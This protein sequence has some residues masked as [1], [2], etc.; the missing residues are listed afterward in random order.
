LPLP[1]L[2]VIQF[3]LRRL[4]K[5]FAQA[6]WRGFVGGAFADHSPILNAFEVNS[7]IT[8]AAQLRL[9]D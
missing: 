2:P 3:S 9:H 7:G 5:R 4:D 6:A 8:S 1:R